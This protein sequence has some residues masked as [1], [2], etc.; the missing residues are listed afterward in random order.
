LWM[1]QRDKQMPMDFKWNHVTRK[2]K[3]RTVVV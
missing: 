1:L 3:T 2:T